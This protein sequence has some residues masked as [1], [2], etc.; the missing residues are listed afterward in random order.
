VRR[1][2]ILKGLGLLPLSLGL[3]QCDQIRER[4]D[5]Y[6]AKPAATPQPAPNAPPP[7]PVSDFAF[8]IDLRF[9]EF[10]TKALT[11]KAIQ[12]KLT[13]AY[14]GTP[15][16]AARPEADESGI[17]GLGHDAIIVSPGDQIVHIVPA[18]LQTAKLRD[19]LDGKPSVIIRT[20]TSQRLDDG[21]IIDCSIYD[22][23]FEIAKT[24]PARITC[25]MFRIGRVQFTPDDEPAAQA[26]G[27]EDGDD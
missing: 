19:I 2:N 7:P 15:T 21:R 12:V 22:N 25:R 18:G 4:V 11:D 27:S 16:E 3:V 17:L 24:A 8:D 23:R 5:E 26:Q 10:S 6:R 20:S 14:Y 9:D 1:A 13:T